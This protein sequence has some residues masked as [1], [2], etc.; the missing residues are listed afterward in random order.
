ML[1][2]IERWD[3]A[4]KKLWLSE[5]VLW[6]MVGLLVISVPVNAV[7]LKEEVIRELA[8]DLAELSRMVQPKVV[9]RALPQDWIVGGVVADL[10]PIWQKAAKDAGFHEYA[11]IATVN[12]AFKPDSMVSFPVSLRGPSKL[13]KAEGVAEQY[14][15]FDFSLGA[16]PTYGGYPTVGYTPPAKLGEDPEERRIKHLLD[17]INQMVKKYTGKGIVIKGFSI[18]IPPISASVNFEF[19]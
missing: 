17:K 5:K 2:R 8:A 3:L 1:H 16:M 12:K 9:S 10:E 18:N 14:S 19:E 15:A 6:L 4:M 13:L 11:N 7:E